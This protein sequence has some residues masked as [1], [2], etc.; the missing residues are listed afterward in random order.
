M[1][2]LNVF[3]LNALRILH[4]EAEATPRLR[5]ALVALEHPQ[6]QRG[7]RAGLEDF[8]ANPFVQTAMSILRTFGKN[9]KVNQAVKLLEEAG[10]DYAEEQRKS[11]KKR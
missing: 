4:D 2:E 5:S 7:I 8:L 11:K 1:S 6:L 10:K 3:H 9:Y